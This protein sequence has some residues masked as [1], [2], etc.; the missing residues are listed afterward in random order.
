[1][2]KTSLNQVL[3][4]AHLGRKHWRHNLFLQFTLSSKVYLDVSFVDI[5]CFSHTEWTVINI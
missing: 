4:G 1:M 5:G 2:S 3:V